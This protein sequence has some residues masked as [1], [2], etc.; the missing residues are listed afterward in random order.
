MSY[1]NPNNTDFESDAFCDQVIMITGATSGL[2]AALARRLA[3]SGAELILT[4]RQ[5]KKLAKVSDEVESESGKHPLLL[6][7]DLKTL[8]QPAAVQVAHSIAREVERVDIVIYCAVSLGALTPMGHY[9]EDMW[10]R[11][12]QINCHAPIMLTQALWPLLKRAKAPKVVT[13]SDTNATQ[14]KPYWGA[15]AASK[16]ALSTTFQ[17]WQAEVLDNTPIRFCE[18][19]PPAMQTSL[20]ANAYPGEAAGTQISP[21]DYVP[22]VLEALLDR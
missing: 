1:Q 22:S 17:L 15:Y 8:T 14:A 9:P 21:E 19:T 20:R 6:P 3:R 16:Q 2:G 10:M 13:F 11:V 5:T 12:M 4:S 7:L 18:L